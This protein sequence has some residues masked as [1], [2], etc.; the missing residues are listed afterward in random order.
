MQMQLASAELPAGA[1]EFDGQFK[2]V[3]A[4]I[5]PTLVEYVSALQLVHDAE[6]F[7]HLYLP[8]KQMIHVGPWLT[9]V[10]TCRSI[11][12]TSTISSLAIIFFHG[13]L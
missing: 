2:H 8:A 4:A 13:T 3:D 6:P 7:C 1:I 9:A 11:K 12:N 5:A 10:S